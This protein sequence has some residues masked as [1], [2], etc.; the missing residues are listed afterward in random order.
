MT[1]AIAELCA[2][3]L[4]DVIALRRDLHRHPEVGWCEYRTTSVVR[5]RL[6]DMPVSIKAGRELYGSVTRLGVP[7]KRIRDDAASRALEAGVAA[8]DIEAMEDGLTGLSAELDTSSDGP[9][10]AVRADLD[11]LP[12]AE[13][14]AQDHLPAREGF[15]SAVPGLMHACAH[16]AHTAVVV[17]L[18]EVLG[19]LQRQ[20]H[21][22]IRFLFQPAE[23]G[24]RGADA[25]VRAGLLDDVDYV[26]TFHFLTD[27]ALDTGEVAPGVSHM[28][29]TLKFEVR[30]EGQPSQFAS[31]PERGRNALTVASAITLLAHAIPKAP[32]SRSMLNI[33]RVDAGTAANIVPASAMMLGEA[34]ADAQADLDVLL[35]QFRRLC[36]GVSEA[37]G[38]A[39]RF[40]Q[41]GYSTNP[42]CDP[43]LMEVV[44]SVASQIGVRVREP[45]PLG[46]SDDAALLIQRAQQRGGFG[47]YVAIGGGPSRPHH[48]P[49]F[50]IDESVLGPTLELLTRT[51]VALSEQHA[52]AR[53]Q[54]R[55]EPAYGL[56]R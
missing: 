49:G 37:F 41:T 9:V 32:G 4:G 2:A 16:D 26:V 35:V 7:E 13:S 23:E 46:A 53:D 44:A 15:A 29:P 12:V 42:R 45:V 20:L 21:G 19:R 18:V 22:R 51:I 39:N 48:S 17:G 36:D 30:L 33:G 55:G 50:D 3:A 1:D 14:D 27:V 52:A 24:T 43:E 10:I 38:I 5:D 8:S 34:R 54:P 25:F 31:A 40:E 28:L 56:D 47:T 6:S 11:A